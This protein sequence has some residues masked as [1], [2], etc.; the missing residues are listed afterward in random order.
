MAHT[1]LKNSVDGILIQKTNFKSHVEVFTVS[2]IG[3]L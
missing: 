1:Y 2:I 3:E